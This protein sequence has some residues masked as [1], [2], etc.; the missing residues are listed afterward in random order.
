MTTPVD[1]LPKIIAICGE[2]GSGKDTAATYLAYNYGYNMIGFSDPVYENLYRLNPAI[3][4]AHHRAVY[5]QVLVDK[6]GWDHVK[7]LYPA[8]RQMLRVEG[9]ENGRNVHGPY[10]WVNVAK[11]RM[12][13]SGHPRFVIRDLR[14]PE[15]VELVRSEGGV[16]WRIEGR[17]SPEVAALPAHISESHKNAIAS[18]KVILNDGT[19]PAFHRKINE[20]MKGYLR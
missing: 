3:V 19:L 5:L 8:V 20:I 12:R 15:E 11:K 6:H 4:I 1:K 18:D 16:I 2:I 13:E 10:C 17:Q 7:R 14:F 9:T